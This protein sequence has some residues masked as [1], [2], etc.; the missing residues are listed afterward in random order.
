MPT[1]SNAEP[2]TLSGTVIDRRF[3]L[4]ALVGR[5]GMGT[6]WRA[7]DL[8][9]NAPV[10]IKLMRGD[11]HSARFAR[12]AQVLAELSHPRVVR[13]V[14]HGLTD[15]G[16]PFLAMEWLDGCDLAR[17]LLGP[18]LA[19]A[20]AIAVAANAAEALA[21]AHAR[22]IVHRDVKPSNLFLPGGRIDELKVLDF[23]IA[24]VQLA[25]HAMTRTGA[26]LGTPGYMAP[27][28][29]RGERDVDARADV[30][31]LGCV[32]YEAVTGRPPFAGEHMM[33]VLAKVL[34]EDAP[35]V[36]EL[37]PDAPADLERLIVRML[38]K[39]ADDRPADAAAVIAALR[40]IDHAIVADS[41]A[42]PTV[43][44]LTSTEQRLLSVVLAHADA[45]H[46]RTVSPMDHTAATADI[47]THVDSDGA[48]TAYGATVERLAD[49]TL[50]AIVASRGAATD[51]AA[52][53]AR[54][55]LW[56]RKLRPGVAMALATG[57]GTVA[58]R[59]PVGDVIDRA[60][61]LLSRTGADDNADPAA[62]R[63]DDTTAGLLDLRFDVGGDARGLALR[64]ERE[65]VAAT[66]TLLGKPTPCV[67]RERELAL[68][69]GVFAE[70]TT[71]SLAH[72]VLV[73]AP[74]G[75]GKSRLTSEFLRRRELD[76]GE[77][78]TWIG[79][80][81]PSSAGSSFAILAQ[82]VRRA[83]GMHDGESLA[84]RSHKLRA[85]VA[86]H[87]AAPDRARVVEFLG[88]L[89]GCEVVGTPSEM[90]RAARASSVLMNDQMR[91]A[92][93]DFV[94]GECTAHP[95]VFLLDDL[96]WGDLATTK[97]VAAA[98]RR[99]AE[100]PFLVVAL[101]RP[102]VTSQ[103]PNLWSGA[104]L[105]HV[106]LG[107]LTA[108]AGE[109]L[110]RA[111]LGDV[112]AALVDRIVAR[113]GGNAFNLEE[114]IRAVAEGKGDA[115]PETVLAMVQ[116]RLDALSAPVRR[117]LRAA[118]VFGQ[119]FW[120]GGVEALLGDGD[121]L[122]ATLD[123][124]C[125]RE[126]IERRGESRF[127]DQH[128][129]AFRHAIVRDAAY[130]LLTDD[131]RALGHRLAASWLD[132]HGELD[133][134]V[135]A[136]HFE[137]GGDH[138]RAATFY[139]EAAA[140]ALAANDMEATVERTCRGLSCGAKGELRGQLLAIEVE[141][142]HWRSDVEA[143]G[144]AGAAAMELLPTGAPRWYDV[145]G[146]LARVYSAGNRNA[147]LVELARTL[148][149]R[150]IDARDERCILSWTKVAVRLMF[151]CDYVAA[152]R[153]LGPLRRA[154]RHPEIG[155]N[156]RGA[157]YEALGQRALVDGNL[158]E[159]LRFAQASVDG[160]FQ[161]GNVL[162]SYYQRIAVAML[163]L[164]FGCY[165]HAAD[166]LRALAALGE[167]RGLARIVKVAKLNLGMALA[168]LAD[169]EAEAVQR[170]ALDL[171]AGAGDVR[172]GLNAR[173]YLTRIL[174]RTGRIDDAVAMGREAVGLLAASTDPASVVLVQS[175]LAEA[176]LAAGRPADALPHAVA[177]ARALAGVGHID[178]SESFARIV[179]VETLLAAGEHAAGRD[180]LASAHAWVMIRADS[181]TDPAL[182]ESFLT[183]V[184]E[185]ARTLARA[186]QLGVA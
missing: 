13:H 119:L 179:H 143:A 75:A 139:A 185:N 104:Q 53:A 90:L 178:E 161:A 105:T 120:T 27:E 20:D 128:E 82:A 172:L 113:A 122:A 127:S 9:T 38:G 181:I 44:A 117:A 88:E 97:F 147:E 71:D 164:D 16:E 162:D 124:L 129:Y 145:V 107:D 158:G 91:R 149:V 51:Q 14:A 159:A 85:R 24:R 54:C 153:L 177:A 114:L 70:C 173:M 58:G 52:Q 86:R 11:A 157:L 110:I 109:R 66:R 42:R 155:A 3:R 106:Q 184:P 95:V 180:A 111:V 47:A 77:L 186:S 96:Q 28:Q 5:G 132:S 166:E 171:L 100:L 156:A 49:G 23:G 63:L 17:A 138:A 160:Y 67:G 121:G 55:A 37:R 72:A 22:G 32:L 108:R 125:E 68:L 112:D 148:E 116:A 4:E 43:T 169:A 99:A 80:G 167:Q 48:L 33:A 150:G 74:A 41:P 50:V 168:Y 170:E 76:G 175:S 8:A 141:A 140:Q 29:A 137:T 151:L 7:L 2:A 98:L 136:E 131:D 123:E 182:R 174:A 18:R 81:D 94:V 64:C 61:R 134:M 126:L 10:A 154:A 1:M 31:A 25:S 59:L 101:A 34:F 152:D 93:E 165:A 15:D 115:L 78:E 19:I 26:T 39:R 40:A 118:S 144:V 84:I 102:E 45:D 135:L 56:L 73:T 57:R 30:F 62:I 36:R 92:W 83:C 79:R 142:Q 163:H 146:V 130:S 183:A 65:V 6:V 133:A 69:D 176:L 21:A 89:V 87:V 103:F 60:V 46:S 35:R 12:E